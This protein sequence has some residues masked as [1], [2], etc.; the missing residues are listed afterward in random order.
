[1]RDDV[2]PGVDV[3]RRYT[4]VE[5]AAAAEATVTYVARPR[6][7]LPSLRTVA[8]DALL[9]IAGLAM[10]IGLLF[11]A[12]PAGREDVR[13]RSRWESAFERESRELRRTDATGAHRCRSCGAS[14]SEKAGACP[15]CGAEALAATRRA[16][17]RRI[18]CAHRAL[19]RRGVR[20]IEDGHRL[21]RLRRLR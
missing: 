3:D 9:V 14:G 19:P 16:V 11:I 1:M 17:A 2:P 10:L 12:G 6:L 7:D 15:A 5:V 8:S 13:M 4:Q 18:E 21:P 20:R